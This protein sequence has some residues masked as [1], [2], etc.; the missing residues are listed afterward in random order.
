VSPLVAPHPVQWV[1]ASPLWPAVDGE[2]TDEQQ[3]TMRAPALLRVERDQFME[4]LQGVLAEEPA[5]LAGLEARPES[6]RVPPPGKPDDW[7]PPLDHL[8]LFQPAH[9]HF[10]LVAAAL[11]CRTPGLPD[12][13]IS[14]A[15]GERTG[16]VLRR[17]LP[18]GGELA[19]VKRPGD[20]SSWKELAG[21]TESALGEDED[22]LPMFPLPFRERGRT[23]RLQAGLIPTSSLETLKNAGVTALH[24]A[25]EDF[26][27]AHLP[28]VRLAELETRVTEPLRGIR[29]FTGLLGTK[30][31]D[32]AARFL[33][34]DLA[35]L[36]DRHVPAVWN[37]I[38][39]E[40]PP[41]AGSDERVL[42]DLLE[43]SAGGAGT[44]RAALT[45]AWDQADQIAGEEQE[46]EPPLPV[47]LAVG[48]VDPGALS[49]A[50]TKVLPTLTPEEKLAGVAAQLGSTDNPKLDLRGDTRYV[51]RCVYE[52]PQCGPLHPPLLSERSREF[53][54][55]SF[56]DVDAPARAIYVTLPVD[57]SLKELRKVRGAV[58]FLM[59]DQLRGQMSRA[60]D[61][62]K[63]LKSELDNGDS[64]NL[65][66]ICS[67]S[68]PIITIVALLLLMIFVVLLNIVFWWLPFFRIC[69]PVPLRG[70]K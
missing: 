13:A 60:S 1:T 59:S 15:D 8:K 28:D 27:P 24:P 51:I 23:R 3:R 55:A 39:H 48:G 38:R 16:F 47:D 36:L 19:W 26:D 49:D 14:T 53:A 62:N 40:Q 69:L 56:F 46:P 67:F 65:G 58:R 5:R 21:G 12:R 37:A 4:E 45:K 33:L 2:P 54:I 18:G 41:A 22:V 66:L 17:L 57:T 11:V 29:A 50:V 6:F 44:W 61:A 30:Q 43:A 35:A 25:V 20:A 42:Y 63:L 32:E 34:L 64:F 70:K 31:R 52:R 68:I 7:R 10:N 9:G